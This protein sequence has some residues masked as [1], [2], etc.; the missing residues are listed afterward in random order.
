MPEWPP[1]KAWTTKNPIKGNSHFVAINYGVSNEQSWVVLVSVIE[2]KICFRVNFEVLK[3]RAFWLP[4]W[5]DLKNI[6]KMDINFD[7]SSKEN[8]YDFTN[9]CLHASNDSGLNIE[10]LEKPVREWFPMQN[11]GDFI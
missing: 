9:V 5:H 4:G 7:N 6:E 2:P 3:D 1:V 11:P 10:L 8:S